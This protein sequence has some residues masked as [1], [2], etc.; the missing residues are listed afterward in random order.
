MA[1]TRLAPPLGLYAYAMVS[2]QKADAVSHKNR[3]KDP[4]F[5]SFLFVVLCLT[6]LRAGSSLHQGKPGVVILTVQQGG[7]ASCD[8]REQV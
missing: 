3:P 4:D 6:T 1:D 2:A 7:G 5:Y 8:R